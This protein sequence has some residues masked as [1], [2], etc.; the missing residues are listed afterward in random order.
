M[1]VAVVGELV[2]AGGELLEALGGDAGE[3]PGE[4][5]VGRQDDRPPRH[6]AVDQRLLPH[7]FAPRRPPSALHRAETLTLTLESPNRR[8]RRRSRGGGRG[9][10]EKGRRWET[11]EEK[12]VT[13]MEER[14]KVVL[15]YTA[16]FFLG[17]DRSDRKQ[18]QIETN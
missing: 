11:R 9:A 15:F 5:R 3:V 4:L 10:R 2:V 8:M 17:L 13:G 6:E 12:T 16:N 7:G 14:N 1:P 18:Q